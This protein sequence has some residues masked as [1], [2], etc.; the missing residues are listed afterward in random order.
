MHT[1]R[2]SSIFVSLKM[3]YY[4]F[5]LISWNFKG[6]VFG[7]WKINWDS[8]LVMSDSVFRVWIM[9]SPRPGRPVH[10]LHLCSHQ[11]VQKYCT[12]SIWQNNNKVEQQFSYFQVSIFPIKMN[13]AK[14]YI[15][16]NPFKKVTYN[17]SKLVYIQIPFELF[18]VN[19]STFST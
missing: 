15:P 14:V 7:L 16:L 10:L 6:R 17:N 4:S 11:G 19:I 12:V 9:G 13:I 8:N 3:F 18:T 1:V 5:K 2:N